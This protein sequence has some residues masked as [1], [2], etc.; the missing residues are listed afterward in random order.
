MPSA[1]TVSVNQTFTMTVQVQAGTQSVDGASA[2]INFDPNYLQVA[3]LSGGSTLPLEIQKTFDNAAGQ[4]NFAAG[5]VTSPYP[6]GTF[7]LLTIV[8][9]A[10]HTTTGT[11]ISFAT[12]LPRQTDVTYTG[13]SVLRTASP[14]TVVITNDAGIN[15]SV[16]LQGRPT[17]PHARWIV[18]LTVKLFANGE[19]TPRYDLNAVTDNQGRFTLSGVAPGTYQA[20]VKNSHT[21]E[22]RSTITLTAGANTVNFGALREG[23]SNNDNF[24]SLVDF[25]ILA[26]TFGKCVGGTGYDTRADFNADTCISLLDFS[27]LASNFGQSGQS[28]APATQAQGRRVT[29]PSQESNV[30]LVI[31]PPIVQVSPGDVFTLTV[32]VQ[33]GTQILDGASA[34]VNFDPALLQVEQVTPGNTFAVLVQNQYNNSAGTL[35]FT[36]G[37]FSNFPSGTFTL[38]QVRMRAEEA[39]MAYLTFETEQPRQSDATYGGNSVLTSTS[40]STVEIETPACVQAPSQSTLTTPSNGSKV[41]KRQVTLGWDNSTPLSCIVRYEIVLKQDSTQSSVFEKNKNVSSREYTTKRLLV[42]G[43]TYYWRVRACN[44]IGCGKW[45]GWWRFTV[46]KNAQ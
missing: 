34:Y 39:G 44:A 35:D 33:S 3:S 9:T 42:P 16:I 26:S 32:Q 6:S 14:A 28:A 8:F 11:P 24:V 2:Y 18:P 17:P 46:A 1:P 21:L 10:T 15:G 19:T 13:Q 30:Q 5:K 29:K 7:T 37:S 43:K 12:T 25:S 20:R 23:D 27:L 36:A 4:I 38:Y 41:K 31:T 45:S 40:G 22:S